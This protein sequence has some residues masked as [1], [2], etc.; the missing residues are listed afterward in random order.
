VNKG[1][2]KRKRRRYDET[3][4]VIKDLKLKTTTNKTR[5]GSLQHNPATPEGQPEGIGPKMATMAVKG[6]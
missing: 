5:R 1:R 6:R 4:C 3:R 2:R